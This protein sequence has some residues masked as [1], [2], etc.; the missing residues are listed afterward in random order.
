[1]PVVIQTA[2]LPRIVGGSNPEDSIM[3]TTR[4]ADIAGPRL[5]TTTM[6]VY[7]GGT[8]QLATFGGAE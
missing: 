2:P 5:E 6:L 1:V 8:P 7:G 4:T 3:T